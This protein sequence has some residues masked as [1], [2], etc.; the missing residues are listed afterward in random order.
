MF[1]ENQIDNDGHYKVISQQLKEA[2]HAALMVAYVQKS[3]VAA[4]REEI[5]AI[6]S[7][8]QLLC[9]FDM[10]ITDPDAI[11]ELLDL[12]VTVK[13]YRVHRGTFHSKIWLFK[14]NTK[15][16]NCL[17]GSANLSR[18]ALFNNIEA[19]VLIN[20]IDEPIVVEQVRTFFKYLWNSKEHAHA[21]NKHDIL[22][23][24][25]EK[26]KRKDMSVRIA[27]SRQ[28][29][30]GDDENKLLMEYVNNWISPE[31]ARKASDL[32]N[33]IGQLWRGWYI[34]PD[35]GYIDENLMNRL[36]QICQLIHKAGDKLNISEKNLD[37]QQ[38]KEILEI[39]GS[40]LK[41]KTHKLSPR[42]LFV[43]QEKNYLV[44]I[45]FA[46][47]PPKKN[48][49]L[50]KSI[51]EL[52]VD[53]IRYTQAEDTAT[54]RRIYTEMMENY[55]Y[56]GLPLLN[57][58]RILLTRIQY[59]SFEEFSLFVNQVYSLEEIENIVKL[60]HIFRRLSSDKRAQFLH[61]VDDV[62]EKERERAGSGVRMNYNKN[63]RHT[64]SAL[65]WCDGLKYDTDKNKLILD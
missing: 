29:A 44:N 37:N 20:S 41:R 56:F 18:D 40:N 1:V 14:K 61:D 27:K 36:C 51:L 64:M 10:N 62:F 22:L 38:F 34:I 4:L 11:K 6:G 53:G 57:F 7:K 65:G 25:K 43:R 48:H 23:W 3:G 28:V 52:T 12:G 2:S 9:S 30:S 39:A 63:A 8:I 59:L 47:H 13:V 46:Q 50:D 5:N 55:Y 33:T 16:W 49:K 19:S 17:V 60:I 21:V 24:S 42:Q 26:K 58:T 32:G 15:H 31:I 35:H 45:G 54:Q